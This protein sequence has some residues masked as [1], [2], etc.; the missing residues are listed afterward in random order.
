MEQEEIHMTEE[1]KTLID[2]WNDSMFISSNTA[3]D[4][5]YA[6]EEQFGVEEEAEQ[7]CYYGKE[8]L[9]S[10]SEYQDAYEGG[11]QYLQQGWG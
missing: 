11:P 10:T 5:F 3:E 2:Q 7:E 1:E 4:E 9:G 8:E 6:A